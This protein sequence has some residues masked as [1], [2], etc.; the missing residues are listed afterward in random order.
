M[1]FRVPGLIIVICFLAYDAA[2]PAQVLWQFDAT[3]R[4]ESSP[5]VG[6]DGTIYFGA[7]RSDLF[8]VR[9]DGTLKWIFR[10]NEFS[11]TAGAALSPSIGD[12]GTV[13]AAFF[14]TFVGLRPDGA[15]KWSFP[16]T[17]ASYLEG[18]GPALAADGSVIVAPA[19]ELARVRP[20][21]SLVWLSFHGNFQA[22]FPVI[23]AGGVLYC[24]SYHNSILAYGGEGTRYWGAFNG[25][26]WNFDPAL[27]FDGSLYGSAFGL[28]YHGLLSLNAAGR[29]NWFFPCQGMPKGSPAVDAA[30]D[31][32]FGTDAGGFFALHADGTL[33]WSN[34]LTAPFNCSPAI[35]RDGMIYVAHQGGIFYSFT[36]DGAT[37][38]SVTI[39]GPVNS[40][41]VIADDG[42]IYIGSGNGLV[43]IAGAAP[44]ASSAWP[45]YRHDGRH[46]A[47]L[48]GPAPEPPLLSI[49]RTCVRQRLQVRLDG[50]S[51]RGYTVLTSSNLNQWI[52]Y[53]NLLAPTAT[54][55]FEIG[56][57]AEKQFLRTAAH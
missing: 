27:S 22:A 55:L 15:L 33:K 12:D 44:P 3:N 9:A 14:R 30:G 41:P 18:R 21:G 54:H 32:Y 1:L 19:G 4:V 17:N 43:A 2:W 11:S 51:G 53:T 28:P 37:N 13:Y 38:W 47:R 10:T 34:L 49:D 57:F 24:G 5:A 7:G 35:D 23:S 45:M 6:A 50:E 52:A 36:P 56:A 26:L 48:S 42:T 40:S 25:Y 39:S 16:A 29:T 8:A 46:T 31:I 20:D